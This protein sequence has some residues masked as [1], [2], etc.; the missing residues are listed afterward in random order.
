MRM[1][2]EAVVALCCALCLG[3]LG[4][5]CGGGSKDGD[6]ARGGDAGRSSAASPAATPVS[7][8][9]VPAG[10][11]RVNAR[12]GSYNVSLAHPPGWR[13][14]QP[15]KGWANAVQWGRQGASIARLG[16]IT[17]VPQANDTKVVAA[18][19]FTAVQLGAKVQ[20]R[21][22]NRPARVPGA[23]SALRVD[24]VYE[25]RTRGNQAHGAD[26]SIALGGGR[27]VAVRVVGLRDRLPLATVDQV[28]R[29]ITVTPS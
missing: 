20:R 25:D 16:V 3:G 22:P 7:P 27:A 17:G 18:A 21:T 4:T 26:M 9:P 29:T 6:G 10:W 1:S 14:V 15:P 23:A 28:L 5:G 13:A 24:Y 11:T 19:V 12:V 2:R 8:A